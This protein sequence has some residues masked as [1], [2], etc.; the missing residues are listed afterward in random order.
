MSQFE[1]LTAGTW[2]IDP[3]H[4]EIGFTV[5]H[6]MSKVRGKF[7]RFEGVVVVGDDPAQS[8]ATATVELDSINTGTQQ[9]DDHLRSGD[10][11]GSDVTPHMTFTSTGVKVDGDEIK[12]TGDLTIKNV[13]HPVELDV[14][15]LGAGNDPWG[16]T[17]AGFEASTVISR[18]EWGIDFN[19][20]LDG[21][22]VMIGDKIT[23]HLNVEAVLQPQEAL[24][25]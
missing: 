5:R 8:V 2:V 6:L 23:V 14:E 7:E 12:A 9:R 22:K 20:P 17:R 4:S 10:F 21:G 15:F 19:I 25:V 24:A 16:G 11:F 1:G 3:S 18:K 13:T